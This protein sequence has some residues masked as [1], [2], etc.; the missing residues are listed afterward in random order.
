MIIHE[1]TIYKTLFGEFKTGDKVEATNGFNFEYP[2]EGEF[3]RYNPHSDYPYTINVNG[4]HR[5][6]NL[7]RHKT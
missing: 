5:D 7:C 6:F 3:I 2:T 1:E 4:S